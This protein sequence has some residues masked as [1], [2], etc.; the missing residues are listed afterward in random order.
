MSV[1]LIVTELTT[2]HKELQISIQIK[3]LCTIGD[4][5]K[6]L[7]SGIIIFFLDLH[8]YEHSPILRNR[9][10]EWVTYLVIYIHLALCSKVIEC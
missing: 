1:F 8:K 10:C 6:V 9:C 2:C 5:V 7:F 4:K 3:N